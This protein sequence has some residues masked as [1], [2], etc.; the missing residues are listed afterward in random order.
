MKLKVYY[1]I[2]QDCGQRLEQAARQSKFAPG[3]CIE[4]FAKRDA[5][6]G[7]VLSAASAILED[8]ARREVEQFLRDAYMGVVW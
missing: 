3:K 4:C 8:R 6:P 2:C 7:D 1:F 5:M